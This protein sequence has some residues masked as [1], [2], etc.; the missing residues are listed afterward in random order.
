MVGIKGLLVDKETLN[1][2]FEAIAIASSYYYEAAASSQEPVKSKILNNNCKL[3]FIYT[4]MGIKLSNF[5]KI[6]A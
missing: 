2:V 4:G 5:C 6:S 1:T 3:S